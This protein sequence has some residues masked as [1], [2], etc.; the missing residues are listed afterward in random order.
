SLNRT[1]RS[2]QNTVNTNL[3]LD[4]LQSRAG[5][6]FDP[7]TGAPLMFDPDLIANRLS[8]FSNPA[9]GTVGNL[10]LTPVTGPG[11]WNL[12]MGLI[13][14]TRINESTNIEFRMEVFNV[15]N[16]T[17]FFVSST[18]LS[19]NINASTFG[20]ITDTFDPRIFQFALKLNF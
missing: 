2:G 5:L 16:H 4:E 15:F 19:Q 14:R 17:N 6:F 10:Q 7:N 13:K 8:L 1:G 20:Q 11:Y 3:T 9:A 18:S 12:D